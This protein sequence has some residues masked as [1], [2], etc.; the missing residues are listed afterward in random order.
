[1]EPEEIIYTKQVSTVQI[2]ITET[3]PPITGGGP[4]IT[5]TATR[6]ARGCGGGGGGARD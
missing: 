4:V 1:M 5:L 3:V 2:V 6:E